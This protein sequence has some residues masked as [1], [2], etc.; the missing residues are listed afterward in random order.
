MTLFGRIDATDVVVGDLADLSRARAGA[1]AGTSADPTR[2]LDA[3]LQRF[4]D[5]PPVDEA[6]FKAAALINYLVAMRGK[7][8]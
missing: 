2:C 8:A 4:K 7:Q 1:F 3:E 5:F 6:R